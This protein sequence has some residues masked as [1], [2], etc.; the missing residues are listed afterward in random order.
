M[1]NVFQK[2]K[3]KVTEEI[4][5]ERRNYHTTPPITIPASEMINC[6]YCDR[7]AREV[8]KSIPTVSAHKITLSDN[9]GFHI[10]LKI[11]DRFYDSETF[12]GILNWNDSPWLKKRKATEPNLTAV[13]EPLP[14][15]H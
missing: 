2:A 14:N 13:C 6:G 15:F 4:V 5:E 12:D 11:D 9:R 1:K 3:D 7:W 8:K 10:I